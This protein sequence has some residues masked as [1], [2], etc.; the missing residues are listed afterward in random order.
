MM[1]S[2]RTSLP[3]A[4]GV[5]GHESLSSHGKSRAIAIKQRSRPGIEHSKA[6]FSPEDST[7]YDA[8]MYDWSTWRMYNRIVSF[9]LKQQEQTPQNADMLNYYESPPA[10]LHSGLEQD[11]R[12]GNAYPV[13]G[14]FQPEQSSY[15][16]EE[17]VFELDI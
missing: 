14:G 6:S 9:R 12:L 5:L 13:A 16:S 8:A 17:G 4:M 11:R 2:Q 15:V 3:T 7:T 1:L 10:S